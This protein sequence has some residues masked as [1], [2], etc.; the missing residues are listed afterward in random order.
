MIYSEIL[1]LRLD[2]KFLSVLKEFISHVQPLISW[3]EFGTV[4]FATSNPNMRVFLRDLYNI[5]LRK[6][7]AYLSYSPAQN[8]LLRR[9]TKRANEKSYLL[10][11]FLCLNDQ[12]DESQLVGLIGRASVNRYVD[13][14][15]FIR[16]DDRLLLPFTLV[17]YQSYF[18]ISE[19]LHVDANRHL[20]GIQPAHIGIHTHLQVEYLKRRLRNQRIESMLEM[21]CGIGIV[22]L[23]MSEKIQRVE[24]VELY[25]RNLLFA[26]ANKS[27]RDDRRVLFHQS[28]LFSSVRGRYD[29]IVFA[30]W[31]PSE[32]SLELIKQFLR[33]A[34][35]FL[36]Q[37]GHIMLLLSSQCTNGRDTVLDEIMGILQEES[38]RACQDM[39]C[40]YTENSHGKKV[41]RSDYYLWIG[42]QS[43][44]NNKSTGYLVRRNLSLK[45]IGFLGRRLVMG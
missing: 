24:G 2:E 21:G 8:Y 17:P 29:L 44:D 39:I 34:P 26:Y 10:F 38:L 32:G 43:T 1:H 36:T 16:R 4:P 11:S 31:I 6:R 28:N 20:Y 14:G 42:K 18:Y 30:P 37:Q 9:L 27:L 41:L 7:Y 5:I 23:E 12:V 33:E 22:S 25:D 45:R 19:A 3:E 13:F 40:S 15:L 35:S